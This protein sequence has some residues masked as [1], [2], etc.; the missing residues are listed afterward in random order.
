MGEG[1]E[2]EQE[3]GDANR[4]MEQ[5]VRTRGQKFLRRSMPRYMLATWSP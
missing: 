2:A 4:R 5:E 3:D 1:N